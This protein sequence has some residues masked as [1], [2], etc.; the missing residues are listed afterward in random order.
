M[1]E[2][3][4]GL[5]ERFKHLQAYRLGSYPMNNIISGIQYF[6]IMIFSILEITIPYSYL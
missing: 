6:I 4:D 1:D 2:G 5:L 3:R